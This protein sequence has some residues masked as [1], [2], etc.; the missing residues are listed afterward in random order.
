MIKTTLS[1]YAI[2]LRYRTSEIPLSTQ[3]NGFYIIN[4]FNDFFNILP[5]YTPQPALP[6]HFPRREND[7]SVYVQTIQKNANS[8]Y[9]LIRVGY[10]GISSDIIDGRTHTVQYQRNSSDIE[11]IPFYFR[12]EIPNYGNIGY[13]ILQGTSQYKPFS[14][15]K[16]KIL[17][18]FR[19]YL[20]SEYKIE[21]D[22]ILTGDLFLNRYISEGKIKNITATKYEARS[23]LFESS[24]KPCK[25]NISFSAPKGSFF[26]NWV[27]EIIMRYIH[28]G[29]TEPLKIELSRLLTISDSE[30]PE[31]MSV[32]V[33][34][35]GNR[36]KID[37][38]NPSGMATNYDI[39][40]VEKDENGIPIFSCI[41]EKAIS[42]LNEHIMPLVS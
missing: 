4:K 25:L 33:V 16:T 42:I 35:N 23:D 11:A 13:L 37:V 41:D 18:Y 39:S 26:K 7:R 15:L 28:A 29:D 21:I 31:E 1:F 12:I 5:R 17:T 30:V 34:L 2:K 20:P 19:S 3:I 22:S 27:N 36:K 38:G 14:P 32:E 10:K 40:D 9:G 6:H 24:G 8:I